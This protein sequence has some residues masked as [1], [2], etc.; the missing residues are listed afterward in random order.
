MRID[1]RRY[2]PKPAHVML[3][4]ILTVFTIFVGWIG[5]PLMSRLAIAL[6]EGTV[7][8]INK[9][10]LA[11]AAVVGVYFLVWRTCI[12]DGQWHVAKEELYTGLLTKAVEQLGATREE[13]TD[14]GKVKT[15]PNTEVRLGAIY[16]LEKLAA[17]Y[18]PLH[19]QIMELL[20]AYVRKNAGEPTPETD[21]VRNVRAKQRE[22]RSEQ[23]NLTLEKARMKPSVE[24][25]AALTVIGRRLERQRAFEA[26]KASEADTQK[27]TLDLSSCHLSGANLEK[28]RFENTNFTSACLQRTHLNETR[29]DDANLSGA[30]L[31]Q[32]N[33]RKASLKDASLNY[34]NL[35]F[36]DLL[37]AQCQGA[38][39]EG[40][41]LPGASLEGAKL[42]EAIGLTQAQIEVTK[43][44]DY[45]T[46]PAGLT[47]PAHWAKTLGQGAANDE[48]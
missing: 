35:Q 47:R 13:K 11:A 43:G 19:W 16:A 40:T 10:V 23:E 21:E 17:D 31:E 18:L 30:H 24:I 38:F 36:A 14:D 22:R 41:H 5:L 26:T 7:D 28:L 15:V 4:L 9:L 44:D 3:G 12:A 8:E 32:A 42:D 45:T 39:F 27:P 34:A 48:S 29:L 1:F 6:E 20:C 33:L 37:S 2:A 46:L 25:Q